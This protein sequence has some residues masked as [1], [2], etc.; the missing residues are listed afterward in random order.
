MS[1]NRF[2][3]RVKARLRNCTLLQQH[4]AGS[5]YTHDAMY[6]ILHGIQPLLR[7]DRSLSNASFHPINMIRQAGYSTAV[8]HNGKIGHDYC[9][10]SDVDG[11][12]RSF[13]TSSELNSDTAVVEAA[14]RW[15]GQ[16]SSKIFLVV[17]LERPHLSYGTSNFERLVER[18][19]EDVAAIT[20]AAERF[21]PILFIT[22]DHGDAIRGV[23]PD[24]K[25]QI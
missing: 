1:S 17:Y 4:F 8:F 2:R 10:K 25:A 20:G 9:T 22:T 13:E 16:Q 5:S 7:T 21:R 3:Q 19:L 24:C 12:T 11:G 23:D 18:S 6:T 14:L 15:I